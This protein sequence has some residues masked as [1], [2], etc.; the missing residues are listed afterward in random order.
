MTI[1]KKTDDLKIASMKELIEPITVIKEIPMSEKATKT[2]LNAREEIVKIITKQ[3]KRLL[4][5]VGPCSIHDVDAAIEYATRLL[6]LKNEVSKN[7][8]IV[9]RVYF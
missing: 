7:I 3:D 1:T 9:M 4:V 2:V 6:K 5:V 8:L